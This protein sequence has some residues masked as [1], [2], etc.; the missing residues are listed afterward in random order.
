MKIASY[1]ILSG[2]FNAYSYDSSSPERLDLLKKAIRKI[3]ADFIGLIDTFRWDRLYDNRELSKLFSYKYAYCINLND[4]R[5]KKKG[6]NNGTTVLTN[7]PVEHFETITIETRDAI[8]TTVQINKNKLDIFTVYLDDLSEDTRIKQT[9]ALLKYI[10]RGRPT[11]V[12]G[13][14][15]TLSIKDISKAKSHIDKFADENPQLFENMRPI[16]NEMKQGVVIKQLEKFGLKDADKNGEPTAPTKLFPAKIKNAI[17]RIDYAFHTNNV[18][19][20]N[21]KVLKD[22]LFNQTSDHYPVVFDAKV[23]DMSD[24]RESDHYREHARMLGEIAQAAT[25]ISGVIDVDAIER[26]Q[27]KP[28]LAE[29]YICGIKTRID[30]DTSALI[31]IH[32]FRNVGISKMFPTIVRVVEFSEIGGQNKEQADIFSIDNNGDVLA[33]TNMKWV[34]GKEVETR[35]TS[36]ERLMPYEKDI[37]NA[38]NLLSYA[39]LR[40]SSAF[41]KKKQGK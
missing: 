29:H 38:P 4:S 11:I 2:G 6:H 12:M 30:R 34:D 40:L 36:L 21:F 3:N 10:D 26:E 37:L 7:L 23:N 1:N 39:N 32:H 25:G 15:N 33:H 17:L 9:Q 5:L 28:D 16:L 20:Q 41:L 27:L 19:V 18:R 24:S 35:D 14:L 22:S 8:K 13:D 31:D